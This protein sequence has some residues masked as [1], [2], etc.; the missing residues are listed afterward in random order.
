MVS[1][2]NSSD[3]IVLIQQQM[4]ALQGLIAHLGSRGQAEPE[5]SGGVLP[6]PYTDTVL[7][8]TLGS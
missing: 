2:H 7:C 6:E 8:V 3:S 1:T 4:Q 5:G